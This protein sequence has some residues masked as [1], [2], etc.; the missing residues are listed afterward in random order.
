M[1]K[2]FVEN[3]IGAILSPCYVHTAFK[4]KNAS[5]L[6]GPSDYTMIFNIHNMPSGTVPITSVREDE[7]TYNDDFNDIWSKTFKDDVKR[8]RGLPIGV[9][10][11]SYI[12]EDEKC[13]GIMKAL[14]EVI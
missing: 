3:D 10:V 6:S 14:E 8:S 4:I 9:I 1:K 12:N 2:I 7:E 11:S 13:L 5:V